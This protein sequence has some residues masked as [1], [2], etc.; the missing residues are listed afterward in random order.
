VKTVL[1]AVSAL[2]LSVLPVAQARAGDTVAYASV[3]GGLGFLL[4]N[5]GDFAVGVEHVFGDH[6]G[7]VVEG[8]FIH[9]HGNPTHTTTF[10]GQAGYRFHWK[11]DNAP[12]VGVLGGYE[13]GFAKYDQEHHGGPYWKYD[14]RH[15]SVVPHVGYRWTYK[16]FVATIRFGG[17]YGGWSITTDDPTAPAEA[18]QELRDRLQFTP[19]KL[20][21]ELSV[22]FRF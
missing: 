5:I 21:S 9:V 13:V 7:V 10:G 3:A 16:R 1:A 6:H 8:T 4:E 2:L 15:V 17:G 12:F 14:V 11:G 19:V 18:A 22:G 20:D